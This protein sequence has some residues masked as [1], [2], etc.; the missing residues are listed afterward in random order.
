MFRQQNSIIGKVYKHQCNKTLLKTCI[1]NGWVEEYDNDY[2]R[3]T[4]KGMRDAAETIS[5][6]YKYNYS[7]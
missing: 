3:V 1:K 5:P 7:P 4:E 6:L 2:V